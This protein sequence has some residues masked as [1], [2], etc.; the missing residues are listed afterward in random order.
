MN[1]T[2]HK[3]L[4]PPLIHEAKGKRHSDWGGM[5][6][7]NFLAEL[8][9]RHVYRVA[10]AYGVIAWL[11]IQVATQVFPFFEVSNFVVRVVVAASVLGFPVALIIAWAFEMTPTGLKRANDI[12]PNEYVPRWST[13]KFAA[14]VVSVAILAAGVPLVHV[15]R[16]KP[17]FL[18]RV[19]AASALAEKSIA[20]LPLLNESGNPG[21]EYF[22][23]GLSEE[24]IAALAQIK[25]LKVIGRSS[26]FRFKDKKTDIKTIGEELGVSTLLEGTVRRQGDQVRIVAELVNTADGTEVW[27]RTFDRELKDIFAVQAEI[28]EA[29]ATSLELTLLGT[30]DTSPKKT[31]TKSMEAHNAYLQGHFY[32]ERRNLEDYRKAVGFFDQAIRLDSDYALAYAERSEAWAWIGDLSS[33]KKNEAWKAAGSDA[34]KAVAVDPNLAQ[35]HAALGWVRFFIEWKFAEGL[36]E[37]RRAQQLSPWNPTASDLLARVVVYLGQFEEAEKLAR[38]SIELDPLAYQARISLARVLFTEGKLDETEAAARKAAE[39]QP[40]AAGSHRWQVFV[41]IQRGDGEA[42]LREA[43]LEPNDGYR[44]FELALAHFTRGDSPAADTALAELIARD[45]NV[46]A[47]Q[48]A[49]VYA[50]RGENDKAFEWLQISLDTHD[51]GT[52]SFFIDPLLRGLQHDPRYNSLLSTIGLPPPL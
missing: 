22:S 16:K 29:V 37:L 45:R 48:V 1:E 19:S 49:E 20:V 12:A 26:S 14:L 30:E 2:V 10:I 34:E 24:L 52:V 38:Q 44:H 13:R 9:R 46:M 31:T 3:H 25:G 42:A 15:L 47:Y 4:P 40:A 33:E 6:P 23:D 7:R 18:S 27:S 36:A 50:W 5:K 32:L 35:A 21:D 43:H 51:T 28:A 17:A 8:K 39:L 41:A 11:L